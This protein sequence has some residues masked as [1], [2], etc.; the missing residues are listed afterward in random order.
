[1]YFYTLPTQIAAHL[2]HSNRFTKNVPPRARF[3]IAKHLSIIDNPA[4]KKFI[5]IFLLLSSPAFAE[6]EPADESADDVVF[7]SPAEVIRQEKIESLPENAAKPD[8]KRPDDFTG[9][10]WVLYGINGS[11]TFRPDNAVSAKV[12][13]IIGKHIKLDNAFVGAELRLGYNV[14]RWLG[15]WAGGVWSPSGGGMQF[16]TTT[17]HEEIF[18][19]A[20][21]YGDRIHMR[22]LDTE[23]TY[24]EYFAGAR[25]RLGDA[26]GILF[27]WLR[28]WTDVYWFT[29]LGLSCRDMTV[30]YE[31]R[32]FGIDRITDKISKTSPYFGMGTEI[33]FSDRGSINIDAN[34]ADFLSKFGT[35][36]MSILFKYYF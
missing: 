1:V 10:F 35:F 8:E 32:D 30:T 16:I 13:E 15:L 36:G 20:G 27:S 17:E 21:I 11:L 24:K 4:M 6:A 33:M 14:N 26:G 9:R 7:P 5:A 29:D 34:A 31:S 25:I 22:A 18:P 3:F 23:I 28:R 19:G 12:D 2:H